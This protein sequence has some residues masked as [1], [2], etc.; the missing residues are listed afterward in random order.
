MTI[1]LQ[2][3]RRLA[4]RETD[5]QARRRLALRDLGPGLTIEQI[6]DRLNVN[7]S[8]AAAL[9]RKHGYKPK[10]RKLSFWEQ[11]FANLEGKEPLT[12]DDIMNLSACSRGVAYARAKEF[13]YQIK[14]KTRKQ[15]DRYDWSRIDWNRPNCEIAEQ[16][17][18]SRWCVTLKRRRLNKAS[19]P[20]KIP[21]GPR[22]PMTVAIHELASEFAEQA[23]GIISYTEWANICSDP[24][25][26]EAFVTRR[27]R[28]AHVLGKYIDY[29]SPKDPHAIPG[30]DMR[31]ANCDLTKIWEVRETTVAWERIR[32]DKFSPMHDGQC[33]QRMQDD[34]YLKLLEE[35]KQRRISHIRE[36]RDF[37]VC[38]K[39]L[40]MDMRERWTVLLRNAKKAQG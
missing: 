9:T 16:V 38:R 8:T 10:N 4:L 15:E 30:M 14:R 27:T 11:F 7:Y 25:K 24:D 21:C 3:K 12:L 36:T 34:A 2:T 13:G 23:N 20:K 28:V 31:L 6:A 39:A 1:D 40:L 33:P 35:E 17:G 29:I 32:L 26:I 18:C 5:L 37:I 22:I 19:V